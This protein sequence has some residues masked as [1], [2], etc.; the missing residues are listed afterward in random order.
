MEFKEAWNN[1]IKGKKIKRRAWIDGIYL[2]KDED[3]EYKGYRKEVV[4]FRPHLSMISTT[5]WVIIGEEDKGEYSFTDAMILLK[6]G[7]KLKL[8]NWSD[9][10]YVE[11][12][13]DGKEIYLYRDC[14]YAFEP[15]VECYLANDWE[16]YG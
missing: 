12:S 11:I 9:D 16:I 2:M 4:N 3:Y 14:P 5:T 10:D 15:D 8:K 6:D 7:K 13:K 1:L